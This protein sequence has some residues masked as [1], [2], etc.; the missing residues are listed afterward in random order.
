M[1]RFRSLPLAFG[2]L[3]GL[4]IGWAPTGTSYTSLHPV[5]SVAGAPRAMRGANSVTEDPIDLGWLL[6]ARESTVMV[7]TPFGHGSGVAVKRE[8]TRVYILTARHVVEELKDG[9][10]DVRFMLGLADTDYQLQ[11]RVERKSKDVDLALVSAEDPN[12]V[13]RVAVIA[14]KVGHYGDLCIAV[15]FPMNV[16]PAAVTIGFIKDYALHD[17][18]LYLEHS[19]TIWFGNSGGPL[20]ERHGLLIGINV[21]ISGYNGHAASDRGIAVEIDDLVKFMEGGL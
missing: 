3:I 18:Q 1:I 6:Q 21:M 17:N 9:S 15:G 13:L 16:F 12:K 7:L 20:F 5:A 19:A 8:G 10:D 14:K 11:G 2:L 4:V